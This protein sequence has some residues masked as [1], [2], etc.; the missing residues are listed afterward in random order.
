[1]A[2]RAVTIYIESSLYERIRKTKQFREKLLPPGWPKL[3]S[4]SVHLIEEGL[5]VEELTLQ[6]VQKRGVVG[7]SSSVAGAH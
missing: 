6:E 5:R 1:V 7:K 3:S 4:Y 2:K